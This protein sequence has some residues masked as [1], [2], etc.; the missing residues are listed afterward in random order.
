VFCVGRLEGS[1]KNGSREQPEACQRRIA[2]CGNRE[3][4]GGP[5]HAGAGRAGAEVGMQ[6]PLL[7]G[8][9]SA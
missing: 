4:G 1:L 7:V 8:I 2:V 6:E 9:W 3:N 5:S